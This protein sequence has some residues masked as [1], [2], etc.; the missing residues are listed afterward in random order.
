MSL[1]PISTV[2]AFVPCHMNIRTFQAHS[3]S[4]DQTCDQE[5]LPGLGY[6][7]SDGC[8][9]A[10]DSRDEDGA[11]TSEVVV[12]WIRQPAAAVASLAISTPRLKRLRY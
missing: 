10:N 9:H 4:Q 7:A 8:E 6:R 3:D 1:P 5:L 2:G 12:A 11:A